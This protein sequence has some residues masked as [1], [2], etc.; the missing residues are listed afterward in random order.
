MK[1]LDTPP[2]S[3]I[4]VLQRAGANESDLIAAVAGDLDADGRYG[5]VWIA[6]T[7]SDL[8]VVWSPGTGSRP[9][10]KGGSQ[11][12]PREEQVERIPLA[13]VDE[14]TTEHLV[15]N[16]FLVAT[17]RGE[18]RRLCQFTNSRARAFG[19]FARIAEKVRK[20]EE[21]RE[22]DYTDGRPEPFCPRCGRLYPNP[23]RAICPHC[24][25]RRAL[26]W[27]V[28]S[29][30]GEYKA[31][32]AA[33][34][35]L[36]IIGSLLSLISPYINGRIL[37]D[38]VLTPGGRY[39][40]RILEVIL[41]MAAFSLA[42]IGVSIL[43]ARI[44]AHVTAHVV[45]GVKARVFAALQRLSMG[46]FT[47]KQTG[48]LMTRVHSDASHL[49]YFFH[50]GVPYFIV[51]LLQI[52]GIIIAMLLLSWRLALLVLIPVPL[53]VLVLKKAFPRLWRLFTRR[54]RAT[55]GLN[56]TIND[57][58]TGIRVVK[59]FGKEREEIQRFS[60]RNEIVY[61]VSL[62]TGYYTSTLFPMVG[63]LMQAGGLIV[64]S[65][66]GW[67]ALEGSLSFGTLMTFVYYLGM[68]YGPLEFMTHIVDWWTSAMNSA[69]RIFEILDTVPQVAERPDPVRLRP[70]RGEIE[71]SDVTFE[72]EPNRPVLKNVSF[73]VKPGEMIGLVGHSGAGKS[74]ITNVICRFYDVQRGAVKIDGV[75]VRDLAIADLRAQIGIVPQETF[76]FRG[77]I[78]EN[79][80][81]GRPDAT[82]EEIIRAAKA[83]NA[84]DFIIK[85]PDGYETV[86]GAHGQDLSGGEK[87]RISIARAILHNPRILILDEATA[88]LDTE[89]ERQI[90]EALKRLVQGRTTIAIAHRLST[91]RDA[92]RLIV[93]EKG[94]VVEMGTHEEL[95]ALQGV[96]YRLR[97]KQ[98]EAL[99][100]RGIAG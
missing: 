10:E 79:I 8:F 53:I 47:N 87:Q 29:F 19:I 49:Q 95:E 24:M 34:I 6:L 45:A 70:M 4:D 2:R 21:V 61:G 14:V 25:D 67:Q 99:A 71:L 23:D 26:T 56:A 54:W 36:M 84:H 13:G 63:L 38:E 42:S 27:R 5:E 59:A 50:D 90:Q 3:I 66:G 92:D 65:F 41:V 30:F 94:E 9:P 77:T 88:S 11:A 33:V 75:D 73:H 78:A 100:I 35:V 39:E 43:H 64:W 98:K 74:T 57:A 81:Y 32:V 62:Q 51:N 46:F 69:H 97:E 20:G 37:F 82:M 83:A 58:L 17:V 16:G 15:G 68:L 96:Y 44:N 91:L 86:I 7:A 1:G 31:H 22:E 55:R 89:T 28:L 52:I 12:C 18:A 93:I 76:L 40:G 48:G 80:A 60:R 85:L 72:Y